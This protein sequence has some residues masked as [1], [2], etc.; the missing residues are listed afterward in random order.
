[1]KLHRWYSVMS[2]HRSLPPH[3]TRHSPRPRRIRWSVAQSRARRLRSVDGTKV[4]YSQTSCAELR[5][6]SNTMP[7]SRIG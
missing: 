2:F 6:R 5:I 7:V 4:S 3:F 1:M